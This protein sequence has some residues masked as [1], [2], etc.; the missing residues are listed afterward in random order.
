MDVVSLIR[1]DGDSV[2][3][4]AATQVIAARL[5][6][7][8][9]DEAA[10]R[11]RLEALLNRL[12]ESIETRDVSGLL[13]WAS[14]L[15]RERYEAGFDLSEVQA[16]FN[17]LEEVVWRRI[18]AE[19]PP[20]SMAEALGLVSTALGAGKD[21]LGRAYVSLASQA[22]APSLNLSRLFDGTDGV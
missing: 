19:V 4:D 20:G 12:L 3:D 22:H 15:A 7:Y 8:E 10:T 9:G 1:R 21:A 13:A 5:P 14:S 6:H 17:A 16:A 18:L 2:V 11:T